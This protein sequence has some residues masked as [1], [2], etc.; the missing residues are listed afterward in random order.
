MYAAARQGG[1]YL[2]IAPPALPRAHATGCCTLSRIVAFSMG[3]ARVATCANPKD[4]Q[5]RK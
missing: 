1:E 5:E 3:R 2:T 4:S